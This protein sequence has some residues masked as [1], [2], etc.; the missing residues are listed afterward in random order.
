M[1]VF[2][3]L[4]QY[5]NLFFQIIIIHTS[6]CIHTH[7]CI[8]VHD[9][10]YTFAIRGTH[11]VVVYAYVFRTRREL[12]TF[13]TNHA[14]IIY[15]FITMVQWWER[16]NEDVRIS[17]WVRWVQNVRR[18]RRAIRE[19]CFSSVV[20]DTSF[21]SFELGRSWTSGTRRKLLDIHEMWSYFLRF[22]M[23]RSFVTSRSEASELYTSIFEI[24]LFEENIGNVLFEA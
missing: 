19:T 16:R 1:T 7:L 2:S 8:H 13:E 10:Y 9:A 18:N 6:I 3:A 12:F 11:V 17:S 4:L 14:N 15:I 20:R 21:S 24:Y 23:R 22:S 5:A